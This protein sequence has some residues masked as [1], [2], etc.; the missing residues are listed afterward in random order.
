[1]LI[2]IH[3]GQAL[4]ISSIYSPQLSQWS[5]RN[6]NMP[7]KDSGVRVVRGPLV[8]LP[9]IVL[10]R[11]C[12]PVEPPEHEEINRSSVPGNKPLTLHMTDWMVVSNDGA[13]A[14]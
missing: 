11:D 1:M 4:V 10:P 9:N 6:F 7:P 2:S 14:A 13:L 3:I 5:Q 12:D 8:V